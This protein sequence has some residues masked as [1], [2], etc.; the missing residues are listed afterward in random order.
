MIY[1]NT[2]SLIVPF[3]I[4]PKSILGGAGHLIQIGEYTMKYVTGILLIIPAIIMSIFVIIA[5]AKYDDMLIRKYNLD[6][7]DL[8]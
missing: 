2:K 7:A 1:N 6:G 4:S 5:D 8:H 3:P